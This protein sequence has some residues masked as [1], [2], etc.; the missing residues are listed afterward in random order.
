MTE[1]DKREN[2]HPSVVDLCDP[3]RQIPSFQIYTLL[4]PSPDLK[5]QLDALPPKQ[6]GLGVI[7]EARGFWLTT[8]SRQGPAIACC[9]EG[10]E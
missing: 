7:L 10:D 4:R 6:K 5:A 8:T 9:G 1:K 2:K 3:T